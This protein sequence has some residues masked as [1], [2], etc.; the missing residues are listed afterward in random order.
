MFNFLLKYRQ[1]KNFTGWREDDRS[2]SEKEKDYLHEERVFYR[3]ENPSQI[4]YPFGNERILTS[5]YPY[6]NQLGVGSCVLH[7][8]TLAK[9]IENKNDNGSY[10]KLSKLFPY[11]L[12][13][14]Y[15]EAGTIPIEAFEILRKTGS[16]LYS[17]V[18]NV[19][20]EAE[21]IAF[22]P[23]TQDYNESR[24][25]SGGTYF[26]LKNLYN[27]IYSLASIAQNGH[28]VAICIFA[29]VEEWR[30]SEPKIINKNLTVD[31]AVVRHEV[32]ILPKSGHTK[33]GIRYVTIQDSSP[34][35]Y[36]YLRHIS[37]DF[38]KARCT[39]AAYWDN[40]TIAK[41]A[42]YPKYNFTKT[43]KYGDWNEEVRNLQKLLIAEGLLAEDCATGYFGGATLA[44]IRLFQAI[45]A[46]SILAPIGLTEP[47]RVWGSQCIK[48]ANLLIKKNG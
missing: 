19:K 23:S 5:P 9:E 43:L 33:N 48:Q 30:L 20:T 36:I 24:L 8:T 16:P 18:P 32:T 12:R 2:E 13:S 28:G 1:K 27:D 34:F 41:S 31:K 45:Y 6:V 14:N 38:I 29:T 46:D 35:G 22:K 42:N 44:G 7:G 4:E 21:A 39:F 17:T 15:P 47:T 26:R 40:V 11:R 3:G 10:V 25:S 37:E